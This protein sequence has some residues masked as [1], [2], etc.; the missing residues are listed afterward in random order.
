MKRPTE[1]I[2]YVWKGLERL[3]W[4]GDESSFV[5]IMN[6]VWIDFSE[7][8][9]LSLASKSSKV[10]YLHFNVCKNFSAYCIENTLGFS[11]HENPSGAC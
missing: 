8:R 5:Y 6:S 9:N 10:S 4:S 7:Q 2:G 3:N 1:R 11:M